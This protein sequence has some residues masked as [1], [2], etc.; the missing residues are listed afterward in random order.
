[1]DERR[2]DLAAALKQ[3]QEDFLRASGN[4][5]AARTHRSGLIRHCHGQA[6]MTIREIAGLVGLSHQRIYQIVHRSP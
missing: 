1:M 3:A 6:G 2:L 4:L 5:E